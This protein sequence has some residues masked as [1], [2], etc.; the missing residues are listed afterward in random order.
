MDRPAITSSLCE[1]CRGLCEDGDGWCWAPQLSGEKDHPAVYIHHPN[2][3]V[4]QAKAAEGC[5]FC[6]MILRT[7]VNY[8]KFEP[9]TYAAGG[10]PRDPSGKHRDGENDVQRIASLAQNAGILQPEALQR[11]ASNH[12]ESR[13]HSFHPVFDQERLEK[14]R[15][16]FGAERVLIR[17]RTLNSG[18]GGISLPHSLSIRWLGS[19]KMCVSKD[20]EELDKIRLLVDYGRLPN[21]CS[22]R[23]RGTLEVKCPRFST[24][25][26]LHVTRFELLSFANIHNVKC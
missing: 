2:L 26:N 25:R 14:F 12:R 13:S 4:L 7:V 21:L 10:N 15:S 1:T 18:D 19:M 22:W 23:S 11:H 9:E 16:V 3:H 6:A 20:V 5:V 8:C 24:Q 17:S